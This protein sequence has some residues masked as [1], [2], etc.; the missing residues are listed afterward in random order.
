MAYTKIEI[1]G[2]RG[3][4]TNETLSFGIPNGTLGSGLSIIVGPNNSGKSTI[5]EAINAFTKNNPPSFP[6][7]KRNI[8]A[9]RRVEISLTNTEGQTITLKTIA[10][11]GSES[12]F[13]ESMGLLVNT[14]KPF[15]VPSRRMFSP[16]FGKDINTRDQHIA[17]YELPARRGQG[18][19]AFPRRLFQIQKNPEPFN[20]E[21]S[22]VLDTIPKWN[23][24][25][26]DDGNYYLKF[27]YGSSEHSSD[28]AGEGLLS[29]FIIVDA[30]YD[31]N[32]GDLIVIDEPELSIHPALQKK[33][34][35]LF[36]EYSKDRQIVISTHSPYF[37]SWDSIGNGGKISRVVKEEN[38]SKVYELSAPVVANIKAS[39]TGIN[40][41]HTLG[42]I[43]NEV[44]FL[45]ENI[46]L[47]EGQEDVVVYKKILLELG[48]NLKG[49]FYGWGVGGADNM[50]NIAGILKDLGFKKVCGILDADK[51]ANI[52]ALHEAFP[53]Y[54]FIAISKD[55]VRDKKEIAG[56]LAKVG[57]ATSDGKIKGENADEVFQ[58]FTN[59]NNYF[60]H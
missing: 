16:S 13:D 48:L 10:A 20:V 56:K 6:E 46:I 58:L 59:V 57:L 23:I 44:F 4:E 36:T 28:G 1:N 5:T 24:E 37:I 51:A 7:G 18:F 27:I 25:Q 15:I 17:N 47:V 9:G 60:D 52:P 30:L 49:D 42:L 45:Q 40:N 39:L 8:K 34:I 33:L 19:N 21:I 54:N 2:L 35:Q 55:D 31:S 14:V 53:E 32:P 11:G 29:V 41:P 26:S 38:G 43:A 22:K 3:F 50:K 12:E